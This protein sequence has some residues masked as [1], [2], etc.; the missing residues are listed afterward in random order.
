MH[1][2]SDAMHG[3]R[4]RTA[5]RLHSHTLR[6]APNGTMHGMQLRVATHLYASAA[7]LL[8]KMGSLSRENA[9]D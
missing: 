6:N 5:T 2:P 4:Q 9:L 8:R 7:Q 1:A 3:M